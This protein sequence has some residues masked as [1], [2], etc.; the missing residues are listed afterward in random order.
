MSSSSS[1]PLRCLLAAI[2][3]VLCCLSACSAFGKKVLLPCA[4]P[5]KAQAGLRSPISAVDL[6]SASS[7]RG[8]ALFAQHCNSCHTS[9]PVSPLYAGV[10]KSPRLNCASYLDN[11][12]DT[13]LTGIIMH[14]GAFVGGDET[15]PAWKDELSESDIADLIAYLR[16]STS[17]DAG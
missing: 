13:Y 17:G 8:G 5:E 4:T 12:S 7:D 15:M 9:S 6:S 2:L 16:S 11:V 3:I 1:L 14:G 10:L